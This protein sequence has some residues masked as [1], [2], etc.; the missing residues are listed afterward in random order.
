MNLSRNWLNEFV[1][2]VT[3]ADIDDKTF[4]E[5]MSISGSK[6]ET[7]TDLGAEIKNVVVGR[8]QEMER[9]PNSDHMWVCQ[10]DVGTEVTQICT[11]AWN[12]HVGD[13]IPVAKHNS[14]LPGGV[15][16]TKGKLR[17]E[18]SNG[19]LCSLK[20]L[21]LDER[22]FPY[23]TI[24]A[25]AILGNYH[26]IDPEKPSI[27]PDIKA[28]DKIFGK[29]LAGL[30]ES[31]E[32][33]AYSEYA[34]TVSLGETSV[35]L[36]TNCANIHQG[37]LLAVNT[38]NNTVCTLADL[39]ADQREFP[40]CIEDGIFILNE[41]GIQPGDDIKPI[42]GADDHVVE[43]EITPNRPDCL[44]VIGLAREASVTFHQPLSLHTPVV[45]GTD[46]TSIMDDLDV[47]IEEPELCPRYTARMV[48][49]VKIAPSPKW[50][51][52]R[53]RA[54][55]VRPINNIVDITNYVMLEYGQ[56]MH[57]F[58][59]SCVE[60][61]QLI[62][63]RAREGE[64]IQTLDGNDRKLTTNM[65]CICDVN[66]PVCVAGVMGGA[67]S[68]ILGDTAAV[69]FESANFN[70]VSV[71]RTATALGMRTEASG[72]YEKGLDP[73]N[74]YLGVQRACELV[75]LLGCGEVVDGI[76]DVIAA[77]QNPV[78]LPLEPEKINHL[79][80][81]DIPKEDMV[82]I[83]LRLGFTMD[84]DTIIVPSWR[85]DVEHYSD[86]AEEVARFYGYNNLPT[87]LMRGDTTRGGLSARQKAEK[88][89]AD[90][91]RSMGYSEIMT[92]S[93]ISPSFYDKIRLDEKD[94]Q[95][96]SI[97]I[98]NPL[99][100]DTSIMRT[101]AIP[102]MLEIMVRNYNYNN[103]A[104]RL[105]E[106]A[107]IYLPQEGTAMANEQQRLVLGAYGNGMNFFQLKGAVETLLDSFK[108]ANVTFRAKKDNATFHPGR[109]AEVLIDGQVAGVLGELHPLTAKNYGVEERLYVAQLD[110][111]QMYAA[112]HPEIVYKPLP[113]FPAVSRDIA[114]VCDSEIPVADL[115]ASIEK[116]S[117]GLIQEIALFDIYTGTPIP[118][119]KKSVAFSLKLRHEDRTLTDT[120]AD[121]EIQ[122]V[123]A[124]LK[125][126]FNAVLR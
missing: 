58:D 32:T 24:Q 5:A 60:G 38:A 44:S 6:V 37:D 1:P 33:V 93:F 48:K 51:R 66:K 91:C 7:I 116:A 49:N 52:E 41:E 18:K 45:K 106:L 92:Y 102:S 85:S 84:G 40:N 73:M 81:T 70:G 121:E 115:R 11:G 101:T 13:L 99:G 120:E 86:I 42:I 65:L 56:P 94:E 113:K 95:R 122:L 118:E 100:E 109:C 97:R 96:K 88:Q 19:M 123:L 105:F 39:H 68:E 16:I 15:K 74:T 22:D 117:K 108:I 78:T 75:E 30:V 126:D 14:Y 54:S 111:E 3:V 53:L 90:L 110:F 17:G 29:V 76:I 69:V 46:G 114:V 23:A 10:I 47:E 98:L 82:D 28:G 12:I 20:E 31:I 64:V 124:Q 83:L 4:A 112:Q 89:A 79:L 103:K 57:A 34:L 36:T 77:D 61:G 62:I 104:V 80:G 9:H 72:R 71:R 2:N 119:G 87:T 55:G 26:P 43:Y 125:A 107:R 21:A 63:R 67:N 59:F 8:I 50:M 27:S 25:A 35:Q